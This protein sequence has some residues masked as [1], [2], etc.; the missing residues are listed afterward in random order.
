MQRCDMGGEVLQ[1]LQRRGS[2]G[3]TERR[4]REREIGNHTRKMPKDFDWENKRGADF[5][6]FLQ[7][8]GLK[9][10]SFRS[11]RCGQYGAP[12]ALQCSCGG[13]MIAQ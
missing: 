10:W 8:F 11:L 4:E 12:W 13:G 5:C 9:D 2:P 3:H 6:E 1:V 7:P